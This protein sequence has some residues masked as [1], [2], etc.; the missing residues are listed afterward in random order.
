MSGYHGKK[1]YWC[2][3]CQRGVTKSGKREHKT[4]VLI[5]RPRKKREIKYP[6]VPSSPA[7]IAATEAG[8]AE[9]ASA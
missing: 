1:R 8:I 9:E 5:G 2:R 3:T 6:L 7:V 4:H